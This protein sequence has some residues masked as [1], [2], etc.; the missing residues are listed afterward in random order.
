MGIPVEEARASYTTFPPADAAVLLPRLEQLFGLTVRAYRIDRG[1]FERYLGEAPY[2]ESYREQFGPLFV[3]KALEHWLSLAVMPPMARSDL[4]IDI[5]AC[6]SPFAEI[7]WRRRGILTYRQDLV[8]PY[9]KRDLTVGCRAE[10][11]PF[12]DS[13][14]TAVSLHC[15]LEHFEGAADSAFIREAARVLRPG[16][17]VCIL[18]LYLAESF[19]NV[20][21]PGLDRTGLVFDDGAAVAEVVGWGNRFGRFYDPAQFLRRVLLHAGAFEPTL[22]HIENASDVDPVCYL[23]FALVLTR[24]GA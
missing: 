16:G 1:D 21:D 13:F 4:A 11:L 24:K 12:S 2:P 5:A 19:C 9:G 17:A 20:T 6:S 23:Q 10:A 18:P 8:F 3:E 14:F 22:L 7:A 15:S